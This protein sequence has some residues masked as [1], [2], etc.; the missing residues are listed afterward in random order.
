MEIPCPSLQGEC[1]PSTKICKESSFSLQDFVFLVNQGCKS[2]SEMLFT[3][4]LLQSG[5]TARLF[6]KQNC[7]NDG[8]IGI[9][10]VIFFT[11]IQFIR[12]LL[13]PHIFWSPFL[14]IVQAKTLRKCI[15][16]NLILVWN[17]FFLFKFLR[18][19]DFQKDVV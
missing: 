2:K 18:F 16:E 19:S 5:S 14:V 7:L 10:S 17:P 1:I 13:K 6:F 4:R 3:Q 11:R 9:D 8:F 15:L 12:C